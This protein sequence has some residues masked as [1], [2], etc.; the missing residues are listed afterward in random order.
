MRLETE[1]TINHSLP[2]LELRLR[3]W[4]LKGPHLQKKKTETKKGV[5]NPDLGEKILGLAPL[6]KSLW[7]KQKR[8]TIYETCQSNVSTVFL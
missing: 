7:K 5:E 4:I 2:Y 3:S 6:V 1:R 8:N